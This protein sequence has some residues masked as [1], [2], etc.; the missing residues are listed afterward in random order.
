MGTA[1][2][3]FGKTKSYEE[4][5][6]VYDGKQAKN[7]KDKADLFHEYF[8]SM[9]KVENPKDPHPDINYFEGQALE[10]IVFTGED[11]LKILSNLNTRSAVGPDMVNNIAL[12]QTKRSIAKP[13]VTLFNQS[14]QQSDVP[15]SWKLSY[16]TPIFKKGATDCVSNYRPISL[17]SCLSKALVKLIH[18]NMLEHLT[19][20]NLI[21][22]CQ[23]GF[24]PKSSMVSHLL[25]ML[26]TIGK[27]L[28]QKLTVKA[29][30][31]DIAKALD[32]VWHQALLHK[33]WAKGIRGKVA[34]ELSNRE[35]TA[36]DHN[37]SS[38][39]TDVHP[40]RGP[41]RKYPGTPAY[42]YLHR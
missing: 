23:F 8:K 16:V 38:I 29:A 11:V 10:G 41:P 39:S 5:G 36:S 12:S 17:L 33:L 32:R 27:S 34:C 14:I 15:D 4:I 2:T 20:N 35:S 19:S 3:V 26:D 7:N 42:P 22:P 30:F 37:R 24:V 9:T 25:E 1:G 28:D 18:K 31:L 13:L 6:L 40:G 21:W